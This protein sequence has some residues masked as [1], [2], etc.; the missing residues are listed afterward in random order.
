[1]TVRRKLR[2]TQSPRCPR[3]GGPTTVLRTRRA[4]GAWLRESDHVVTR[5]RRCVRRGCGHRFRTEE[6]PV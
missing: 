4:E 6:R 2:L 3:C 1:V 5:E